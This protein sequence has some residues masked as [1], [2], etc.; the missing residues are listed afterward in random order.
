MN[1]DNINI[2]DYILAIYNIKHTVPYQTYLA[3]M[4]LQ[5]QDQPLSLTY[6]NFKSI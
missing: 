1:V 3:S 6:I 2:N 4:S 5:Q